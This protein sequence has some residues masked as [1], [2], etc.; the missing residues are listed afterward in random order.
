MRA[1]SVILWWALAAGESPTDAPPTAEQLRFF[2]SAIRPVLVEQCQKCHGAAKQW[3]GLRLDSHE[4]LLRGG[5]SG[6][7][8]IP[9]QPDESRLIQ[10]VRHTDDDLKMP[11]ETK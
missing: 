4:A 3:N 2:E 8:I 6:P 1:L 10:A 9:G 7:A 5:D 11:P